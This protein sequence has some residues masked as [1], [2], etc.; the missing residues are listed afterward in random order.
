MVYGVVQPF[1]HTVKFGKRAE[2]LGIED[3]KGVVKLDD[4]IF[5]TTAGELDRDHNES[6]GEVDMIS[7]I[8]KR[9]ER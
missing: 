9:G 6:G 2:E 7:I 8:K 3:S 1:L 5:S 4:E